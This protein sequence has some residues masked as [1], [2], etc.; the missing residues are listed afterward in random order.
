M[1]RVSHLY[2]LYRRDTQMFKTFTNT[3]NIYFISVGSQQ[4]KTTQATTAKSSCTPNKERENRR[5][6]FSE[7]L[8]VDQIVVFHSFSTWQHKSPHIP[9]TTTT[10]KRKQMAAESFTET[11]IRQKSAKLHHSPTCFLLW[12]LFGHPV[13]SSSSPPLRS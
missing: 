5:K 7:L 10:G 11:R 9:Q 3:H 1:Q 12:V 4:P 2:S 13:K 6:T 8:P